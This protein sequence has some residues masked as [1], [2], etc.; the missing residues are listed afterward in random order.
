[1]FK[2]VK[3][4]SP[5]TTSYEKTTNRSVGQNLVIL[6]KENS[7]KSIGYKS[8]EKLKSTTKTGLKFDIY[9]IY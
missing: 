5:K 8:F 1:M 2:K 3:A 4:L 7:A 9:I 6:S